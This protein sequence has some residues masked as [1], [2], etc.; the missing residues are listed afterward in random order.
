[1]SIV[2]GWTLRRIA[3]RGGAL[4]AAALVLTSCGWQGIANVPIPGGRAPLR[5]T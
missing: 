2:K 1:V 3:R 4:L 5:V